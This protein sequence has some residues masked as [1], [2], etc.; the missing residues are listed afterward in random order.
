MNP[1]SKIHKHFSERLNNPRVLTNPEEFLGENFEAVLNFWLILDDLSEEQWR[2]VRERF[3]TFRNKNYSEW[4]KARALAWVASKEVVGDDYAGD[5]GV[6]AYDVTKSSADCLATDELIG[7]H[8]ILED[9]QQ[10][11]T[12]FQMFL[13]VLYTDKKLTK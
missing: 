4:D 9:H 7:M 13:E 6:A 5:A 12:F 1:I 8:K 11:L 3:L 10:P 2:V